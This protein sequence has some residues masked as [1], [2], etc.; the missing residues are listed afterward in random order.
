MTTKLKLTV[1]E[2]VMRGKEFVFD[3]HDTFLL[4]R[5]DDC[6]ICLPDDPCVPRHHFILEINPPD[7]RI[8]DLGSLND[9]YVN[10]K[11]YGGRQMG[12]TPEEGYLREYPQVD[13]H[14]EDEIEVGNT[15]MQ[16]SL[17]LPDI[18]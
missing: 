5:M 6:H 4:G 8:R 7:A 3:E 12:E 18:P 14:D 10:G 13:I 1:T 11:K 9:T 2:G 16:I 15:I 17:E